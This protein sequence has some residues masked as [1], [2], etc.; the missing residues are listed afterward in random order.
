[1]EAMQDDA[2]E[3]LGKYVNPEIGVYG[4]IDRFSWDKKSRYLKVNTDLA[5]FTNSAITCAFVGWDIG[6]PSGYNA[7]PKWREALYAAT[8]LEIGVTEMLLIGERNYNLLKMSAAQQ[9]Y[10]RADDGLP[11]RLRKPLPRGASADRPISQ[12]VLQK[13]IDEYYMLRG[14]DNY[15]PTDEKLAQL[16]MEEF[17]GFIKRGV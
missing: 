14:W 12:K 1:M 17:I 11:E 8:G 5:S 15:G 6:L 13:A 10:R 2:A 7:Y 4:P 9:K 16:N 3:A